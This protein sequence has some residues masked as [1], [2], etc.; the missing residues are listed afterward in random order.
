MG[1]GMGG[2]GGIGSGIGG[3]M[4]GM[5]GMGGMDT[6]C[7]PMKKIWGSMNPKM[8][9]MFVNVGKRPWTNL[10]YRCNS[11]CV[12]EK[13]DGWDNM[14]Y[15]FADSM[16]SQSQCAAMDDGE[17]PVDMGMGEGSQQPVNMG[18]EMEESGM[19]GSGSGSGMG[20][21]GS[22]SDMGGSGSGS[23]IAGSGG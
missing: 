14:Q 17:E 11:P 18:S 4:G 6:E 10:P 12:Y 19:G 23:G 1:G 21:S 5:A 16:M 7:C 9:G 8:D 15:C 2:M 13:K 20:G 22:G 3:G